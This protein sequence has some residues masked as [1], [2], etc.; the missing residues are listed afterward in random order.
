MESDDVKDFCQDLHPDPIYDPIYMTP[1]TH[2]QP[3]THSGCISI[4]G[5]RG[6]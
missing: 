3:D 4:R 6:G 1:F 5:G 2:T